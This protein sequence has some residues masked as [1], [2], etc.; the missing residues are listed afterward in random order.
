MIRTS[1]E[2]TI[3]STDHVAVSRFA[4]VHSSQVSVLVHEAYEGVTHSSHHQ[5]VDASDP[6]AV[7]DHDPVGTIPLLI[8]SLIT[9]M[10]SVAS[11]GMITSIIYVISSPIVTHVPTVCDALVVFIDFFTS[12]SL[13]NLTVVD[14]EVR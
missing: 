5:I 10:F 4:I 11:S 3:D 1:Y 12:P 2:R 8:V 9:S 6:E 7:T 14:P 13:L